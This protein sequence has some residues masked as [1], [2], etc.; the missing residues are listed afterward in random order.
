M[1]PSPFTS[2][3]I[4]SLNLLA[5]KWDVVNTPFYTHVVLYQHIPESPGCLHAESGTSLPTEEGEGNV[6]HISYRL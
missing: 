3:L 1:K 2:D 5:D 4:A 6:Y